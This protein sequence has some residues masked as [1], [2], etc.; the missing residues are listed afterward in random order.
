M[1]IL[2]LTDYQ[3]FCASNV[4]SNVCLQKWIE[5]MLEQHVEKSSEHLTV[6]LNSN[7]GVNVPEK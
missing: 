2:C 5:H 3:L 7:L 4:Y 6:V 1:F